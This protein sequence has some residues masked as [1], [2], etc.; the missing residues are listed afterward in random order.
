MSV[1]KTNLDS[2]NRTVIG[3]TGTEKA[4]AINQAIQEIAAAIEEAGYNIDN[5]PTSD[6][7]ECIRR[8]TQ[9]SGCYILDTNGIK[10]NAAEWRYQKQQTGH[11]PAICAGIFLLC[12]DHDIL[13]AST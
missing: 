8:M 9:Q 1:V 4:I 11:D 6:F 13:I 5:M 10:W 7:A 3:T 12:A 2:A